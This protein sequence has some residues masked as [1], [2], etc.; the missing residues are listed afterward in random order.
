M[1]YIQKLL[2]DEL[3]NCKGKKNEYIEGHIK[4]IQDVYKQENIIMKDQ[5]SKK[6]QQIQDKEILLYKSYQ[7]NSPRSKTSEPIFI[8][9][10]VDNLKKYMKYMQAL[11]MTTLFHLL[12]HYKSL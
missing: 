4:E 2:A 10:K 8:Q 5:D 6:K 9:D 3:D 11:I 7:V 12:P 1:Y